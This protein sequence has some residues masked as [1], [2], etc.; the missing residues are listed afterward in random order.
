MRCDS[1]LEVSSKPDPGGRSRKPDSREGAPVWIIDTTL[2]DGEQAAGVAFSHRQKLEIATALARAGVPELEVGIPAM[3]DEERQL[4]GDL[5]R[6]GLPCRLTAWARACREDIESAS[7]TGIA[8]IH[9]SFPVSSIH[10]EALGKGL[11]W[12]V[13]Q[14]GELVG[15][16]RRQFDFVS[17]GAQDASRADPAFL[18]KLALAVK[19]SRAN[20]LRLADTVGVWNPM[21]TGAIFARLGQRVAGL[22]LGFHGHNDL[23]MATANSLAALAAGANSVDVTVGGLGERAGNAALEQVVMATALTLKR[24]TGID[25]TMLWSICQCVAAASGQVIPTHQ[26]ITGSATREHESGI[27]VHAMLRDRR[28]YEAFPPAAVGAPESRFVL[29]KHT[30]KTAL[31]HILAQRGVS[32]PGDLTAPLLRRLR[33]EATLRRGGVSPLE[34]LAWCWELQHPQHA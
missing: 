2:R 1:P 25:T 21:Q 3:G 27:H 15:Q 7:R 24:P 16:A 33:R 22:A 26:P 23:G 32:L 13:A 9:L 31:R 11:S 19:E 28:T 4:I 10:L 6:L 8:A 5:S 17:V 29:G 30:G 14:V 34:V 20:R 18:E 12:V